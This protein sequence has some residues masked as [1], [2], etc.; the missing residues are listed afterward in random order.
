MAPG[1]AGAALG[2]VTFAEQVPGLK[3][4]A[5]MLNLYVPGSRCRVTNLP[6][7]PVAT[8]ACPPPSSVMIASAT[9]TS[10]RPCSW[11]KPRTKVCGAGTERI[12]GGGAGG[13][14]T[15][16]FFMS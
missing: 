8:G 15:S 1:I 12:S 5:L 13:A 6:S 14:T 3:P 16:F 2:A 9:T 7:G 4:A 11:T 10:L